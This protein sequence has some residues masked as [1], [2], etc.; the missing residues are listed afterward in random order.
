MTEVDKC[1]ACGR[2]TSLGL[3]Q[4]AK[5]RREQ[6]GIYGDDLTRPLKDLVGSIRDDLTKARGRMSDIGFAYTGMRE[7]LAA[8][9][10]LL[11]CGI[12]YLYYVLQE[13][14]RWDA[15]HEN[16]KVEERAKAIY[17]AMPFDGPAG[18]EK[19]DWVPGGNSLKQAEARQAARHALQAL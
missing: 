1:T 7:R 11:T 18:E 10:G 9:E 19:P 14:Q 17:E 3:E 8:T 2:Y 15:E 13:I 5:E 12:S 4:L 16:K 6:P